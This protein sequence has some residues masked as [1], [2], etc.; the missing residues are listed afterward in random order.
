[1]N[2]A[3]DFVG[4]AERFWHL[5]KV[6]KYKKHILLV[7]LL[8]LA[9]ETNLGANLCHYGQIPRPVALTQIEVLWYL[10]SMCAHCY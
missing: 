3:D 6:M 9:E 5:K 10:L 1:M 8:Y 4:S 2:S 7:L